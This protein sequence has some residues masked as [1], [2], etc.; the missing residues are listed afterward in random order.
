MRK[1]NKCVEVGMDSVDGGCLGK[2]VSIMDVSSQE[3]TEPCTQPMSED[4]MEGAESQENNI[5]LEEDASVSEVE[6]KAQSANSYGSRRC[7]STLTWYHCSR[8]DHPFSS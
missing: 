1:Y 8:Q 4:D 7:R 6:I 3:D 2:P 5:D